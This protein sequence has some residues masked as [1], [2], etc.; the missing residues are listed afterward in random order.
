[1]SGECHNDVSGQFQGV[2]RSSG[3]FQ[4]T[5]KG[6]SGY[7]QGTFKGLS[8]DFQETFMGFNCVLGG[9]VQRCFRGVSVECFMRVSG[10]SEMFQGSFRTLF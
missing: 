8:G 4:G 9:S 6:L 5:F 1:V 7:F 3:D 10:G 2:Q